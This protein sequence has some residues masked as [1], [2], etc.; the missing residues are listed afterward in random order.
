METSNIK[1]AFLVVIAMTMITSNDAIIKHITQVFGIGQ[2]MFLRG[3]LV[4]V[5]FALIMRLRKQPIILPQAFHRWNIIRALLE[6]GATFAF[7]TGLSLL[8]FATAS[9]LGFSSPIFLALLAAMLLGEKVGLGLWLVILAGFSGVVIISNP[10]SP[11]GRLGGGVSNR[12]CP[13]GCPA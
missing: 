2:I 3:L 11:S 13:A 5:L 8:P 4:C 1:A 6:L 9:T 7:L 10:F 12:L